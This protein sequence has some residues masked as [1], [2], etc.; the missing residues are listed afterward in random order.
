MVKS[1]ETCTA[2]IHMVLPPSEKAAFRRAAQADK[3]TLS[4][5][6]RARLLEAVEREG[7]SL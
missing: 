7:T 6:I 3:R 5:W 2:R 1:D 4:D